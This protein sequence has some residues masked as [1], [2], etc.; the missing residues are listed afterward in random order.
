MEK[1][2][3]N[4]KTYIAESDY[5]KATKGALPESKRQI[6]ILQ[7]GWVVIGLYSVDKN[8][9][10]HLS[11]ASV[12]RNWGTEKGLGQLAESGPLTNTKIDPCPDLHFHPLTVIARMEVNESNW[13]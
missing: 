2:T 4:G 9:E 13:K 12:I 5:K 3:I 10:C 11:D 1:I 8:G 6:V 7:R